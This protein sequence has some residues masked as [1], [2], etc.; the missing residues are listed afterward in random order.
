MC[1]YSFPL[2]S[3]LV[4]NTLA[5]CQLKQILSHKKLNATAEFH[6]IDQQ[7]LHNF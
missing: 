1:I 7:N 5:V 4:Q 2:E 6:S 3:I